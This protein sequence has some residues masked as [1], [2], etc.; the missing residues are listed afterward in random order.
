MRLPRKYSI[1]QRETFERIRQ[2]GH[3][4][5]GRF[6]ILS[7]LEEASLP[8]L[9]SAFVTSK[10]AA[11][12]AHDRVMIRRRLRAILQK[13][14]PAF[15]NPHRYL[16]TIARNGAADASFAELEK[17]WLRTAKRLGLFPHNPG[18]P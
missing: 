10:R 14:A 1:N 12:K 7:T 17:D 15:A 5:A 3:A 9:M 18:K 2:T 8:Q 13:H 16:I 6:V 11:K 4:K